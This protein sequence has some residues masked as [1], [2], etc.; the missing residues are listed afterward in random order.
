M[1][2]FV[3]I[4]GHFYQPP[5][6]NPWLEEIELQ[7]SAHPFHDWNER[8]TVECYAPNTAS[9]ILDTEGRI[10]DI[11]NNYSR[12]SFNFGPTLLSWMERRQ[13]EVYAAILEADRLGRERFSDHGPAMAQVYSHCIMPLATARD[14]RTQVAWGIR[15]FQKRFGRDPEGM[16]LPETAVDTPTLEVLAEAG[17]RFTVLAPHQA[18]RVRPCGAA[19]WQDVQ[20]GRIDPGRAYRCRLRSG[21]SLTLFFYDGPISHDLAFGG[22][23]QRGEVFAD[24]VE[25]AFADFGDSGRLVHVASDGE[26]YGHHHPMGDMALAYCLQILENRPDIAL[27]VYGEYLER[28]PPEYEVEIVENTSWSCAHGVARWREDCGCNSGRPGWTQ[29]WRKPLRIAMDGLRATLELVFEQR[30]RPC[31]RDPWAARERYIDVVLDRTPANV[32]AFLNATVIDPGE[33]A[34]ASLALE[35]LEMQRHAMLMYTSCGWFF[36]EIS[37]IETTQVLQYA[38]RA[39]QLAGSICG[40]SLDP[41]FSSIL[42]TAPS[43]L[44]EYANG[45][46]VFARCVLPNVMTAHRLGAHYALSMLFDEQ[47]GRQELFCF[48][49]EPLALERVET[50]DRRLDHGRARFSSTITR[51]ELEVEYVAVFFGDHNVRAGLSLRPG[52]ELSE[53]DL[54]RMKGAFVRGADDELST[55]LQDV[56]G[57]HVYTLSHLF[58][59]EQQVVL[60]RIM[61]AA[62]D[63]ID[64]SFRAVVERHAA[65]MSFLA[66]VGMELPA[67]LSDAAASVINAD[68]C[69]FL[70]QGD[71]LE[72]RVHVQKRID[73][74]GKWGVTLD[75]PELGRLLGARVEALLT[76]SAQDPDDAAPLSAANALLE[77]SQALELTPNL[78]KAQNR[79]VSLSK[80]RH[81]RTTP[82][83]LGGNAAGRAFSRLGEQLG[84]CL[85]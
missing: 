38:A 72:D 9:R 19:D 13:P 67:P 3:C 41:F 57:A 48:Q 17:I 28:H 21:R 31:F 6:E 10:V 30:G 75:R 52:E 56:F 36:D 39:M 2:R 66:D 22:L 55:C 68:I 80:E 77:L 26:T 20:V 27:T 54:R 85:D 51:A 46:E 76:A 61:Q 73:Q 60:R 82:T 83:G 35:L 70:A 40:I 37:G 45:A 25:A 42:A 50:P 64:V 81:S 63:E 71:P 24:R 62:L 5:R 23:L 84:I 47:G 4:H 11:L 14:K 59:D 29:G 53:E 12:I 43:N 16:W 1:A 8:V 58:K 44:P 74:A 18:A 79:W 34:A 65:S 7:E 78:W 69:A 32:Q 33:P 15:D 49:V